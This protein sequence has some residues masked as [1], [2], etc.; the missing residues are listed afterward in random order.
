MI[1]ILTAGYGDGHNTAARSVAEALERLC[2]GET[3]EVSDLISDAMPLTATVTKALYQQAI[4][5]F[6][7]AWRLTYELMGKRSVTGPDSKWQAGLLNVLRQRIAGRQPRLIISTYPLYAVLLESLAHTQK[8]PP[9]ATIITDSISVNRIWVMSGSDLFCV[10]DEETKK[11]VIGFGVPES[12]IRVTGFPVSLAFT[13]PLPEAPPHVGA[14]ILYLP[15]TTGRRVAATL[16]ALKPLFLAG[17]KLTLP[18]GKHASRLYHVL[19]RFT[20]EVP[21]GT[22][23]IIGW[24]QRIPEFLRT[25]DVV[26][27]KAG[28]AILHEVLAA[29]IPAVIDYVVPGQEEGNA[30]MLTKCDGGIVTHTAQ[31]TA[32]AVASIL[33]NNGAVGRRMRASMAKLSVPDAALRTAKASLAVADGK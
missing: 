10:A 23:D 30:E 24:T 21:P 26:I 18:V 3:I 9:L 25:H 4:T 17:A 13:E 7:A 33:T 27:C 22:V 19:R 29:K 20:D 32:D 12:K 2:P 5:H 15:S 16:E 31:Q 6:P 14:R 1:L 11:V 28:G 8:V